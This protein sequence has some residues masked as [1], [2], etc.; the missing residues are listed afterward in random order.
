MIEF[1][2]EIISYP[3][4]CDTTFA[5]RK[6]EKKKKKIC[7]GSRGTGPLPTIDPKGGVGA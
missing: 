6:I 1:G 3:K 7:C 5:K 2:F 4:I